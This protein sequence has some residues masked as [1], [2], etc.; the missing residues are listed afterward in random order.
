MIEKY[1]NWAMS[2]G[3]EKVREITTYLTSI[4]VRDSSFYTLALSF[5]FKSDPNDHIRICRLYDQC[6]QYNNSAIDTWLDYIKY[7]LSVGDI[8]RACHIAAKAKREVVD[9]DKFIAAF[10][11]LK[12]LI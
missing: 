10:E 6:I 8:N 12:N 3:I 11:N 1:L 5:E 7:K 9:Q 2:F 4:K